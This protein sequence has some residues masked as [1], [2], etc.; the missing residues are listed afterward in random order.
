[1]CQDFGNVGNGHYASGYEVYALMLTLSSIGIPSVIS[2][3]VSERIAIGDKKAAQR[4][5]KV[6]LT[7]FTGLRT[8]T[9][10]IIICILRLDSNT[11][12]KC[13]RYC[14]SS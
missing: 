11:Y 12:F 13:K 4:I 9:K 6:A 3:L 5:F 8:F 2:K 1:M 7:F 14:N 10:C